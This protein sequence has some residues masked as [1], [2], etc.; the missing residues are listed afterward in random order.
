MLVEYAACQ[1][2]I[3]LTFK[4]ETGAVD[5]KNVVGS[6]KKRSLAVAIVTL[7]VGWDSI[8]TVMITPHE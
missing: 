6:S 2:Y 4:Y 3:A 1:P 5:K 7:G 8:T